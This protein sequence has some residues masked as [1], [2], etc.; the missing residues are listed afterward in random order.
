MTV[1]YSVLI[2]IIG[3]FFIQDIS[4]KKHTI[5]DDP[6]DPPSMDEAYLIIHNTNNSNG[7][8]L[9][10][11]QVECE[12]CDL[13]KLMVVASN[14]SASRIIDTKYAYDLELRL[15]SSNSSLLCQFASYR[16][17][18][19]GTYVLSIMQNTSTNIMCSIEQIGTLSY[20][21]TPAI[22]G[23]ITVILYT[24]L[25]QLW[26]HL[27]CR[28]HF[29][30]FYTN[31]FHSQATD[32]NLNIRTLSSLENIQQEAI[33]ASNNRTRRALPKR[34]RS[35][36]TFRGFSLMVMIF[37]NYGG[38]GYWF[39]DH[40]T[41]NGLT[42]ADLVFPWFTWMMGVSVVLSQRSLLAKNVRKRNILL[43]ICQRT[44]IL[45]LL[46]LSEQ[47]HLI[48]LTNMRI[49]GV[50]QRLATCYFFTAILVLVFERKE[51]NQQ[52][53]IQL[54]I[55][56]N[57][58]QPFRTELYKS[59]IQYWIQW[60]LV[61][62]VVT[63]WILLT[64]LLPIPNCP[65]GY[66]GPGG[67]HN[68]GK[69]WNCTGGAAGYID[70]L[71]LGTSHLYND[72]TC[73]EI[74]STKIPYDPE[75]LLGNLTGILLC[76]LGAQAG[77]SF[78]HS[79]RVHRVCIQWIISGIICGCFGLGLSQ[80]GHSDSWIPINKNLWSLTF[81][82]TL[83]SLAFI[84]LT[85]LYLLVDVRQWFTGAPFLWLGMNSIAIYMCHGLF[86][87][88]FPVQLDVDDSHAQQLAMNLYGSLFWSFIA[89]IMYYKKVFIAI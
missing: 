31:I 41:W 21:W 35:L 1:H 52:E 2:V 13:K 16:F 44:A 72:P 60:L 30:H 74:Y 67:R 78:I 45:F 61:I 14:R 55:D 83:A 81:V 56:N 38:G 84:V 32:D 17:A 27:H 47:G 4:C 3:L 76:Y 42:L 29:N 11:N 24:V 8:T 51:N 33:N 37:V 28:R 65:T 10:G 63:V 18:E 71:I 70:R 22:L 86:G 43:K 88:S 77:H 26:H 23:I 57:I 64:F 9:Y 80:G 39:F 54:S 87:V 62:L 15:S 82:F 46:G 75:G 20:Y 48:K 89:G 85:I 69:Y 49:E 6:S 19:N 34:L 12:G 66:I 58:E 68:H 36:D 5:K 59:I 79:T 7:I 73:T 40:S 25:V 53:T 50:L